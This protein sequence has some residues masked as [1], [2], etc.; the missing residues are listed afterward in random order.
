MKSRRDIKIDVV[1]FN[2]ED[3]DDLAQLKCTADVTG[4]NFTEAETRAQLFR[5]ME[6]F[7]TPHKSVEA[8][9]YKGED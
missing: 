5:S 6:D 9:I 1:A 2:V 7:V 8:A 4:G 3:S